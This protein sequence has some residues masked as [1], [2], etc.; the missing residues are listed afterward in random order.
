[1]VVDAR[2]RIAVRLCNRIID[3]DLVFRFAQRI[4]GF[5]AGSHRLQIG[6]AREQPGG[7]EK[8]LAPVA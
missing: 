1:M 4:S 3:M 7:A 8:L 6:T 2:H 5:G